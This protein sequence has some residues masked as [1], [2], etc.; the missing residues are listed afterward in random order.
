MTE[1]VGSINAEMQS[2]L[3]LGPAWAVW[4]GERQNRWFT[5]YRPAA[6]WRRVIPCA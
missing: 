5:Y 1:P 3:S 2:Q 6:E 4:D